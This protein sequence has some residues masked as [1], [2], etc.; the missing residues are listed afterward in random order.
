[1]NI[2]EPEWHQRREHPGYRARRSKMGEQA[3]SRLTGLSVWD[4]EPGQKAY[5]Y[6]WHVGEEEWILVTA[7]TPTLRTPAGRRTLAE[8]EVIFFPLGEEGAHQVINETGEPVRFLSFSN[9]A[10]AEACFYP[11]SG[12][13]G[14]YE[15][16]A[17]GGG[18]AQRFR[19]ADAVD[20]YEGE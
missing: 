16:Q 8:G 13:V 18:F 17:G 10:A 19:I 20:Y 2:R 3:G 12:K 14:V 5:P 9:L 4:I 1:M 7:G 11:D 15:D 6:H